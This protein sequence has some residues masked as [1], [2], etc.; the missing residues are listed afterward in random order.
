MRETR[1]GDR[2]EEGEKGK[3]AWGERGRRDKEIKEEIRRGN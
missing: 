2:E 1:K 3:Q